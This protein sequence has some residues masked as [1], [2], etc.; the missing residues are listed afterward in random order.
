MQLFYAANAP[1][2]ES[3]KG[4]YNATVLTGGVLGSA[5]AYFTHHV[6]PTGKLELHTH[7]EGK[8]FNPEEK[9]A[10]WGYNIFTRKASDGEETT[11]RTRKMKTWVG[12]TTIGK[13]GKDSFHL[14]YSPFNTDVIHSMHDEVRQVNENL[15][16]CAGYM[17]LGGGPINPGPFVLVGPPTKWV[18][19]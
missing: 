15:Y 3:M 18:G 13:D 4:E 14:D 1:K 12:P 2:F 8:A 5:T 16:I 19:M 10:G 9:N 6:F 7:W 17:A 11:F